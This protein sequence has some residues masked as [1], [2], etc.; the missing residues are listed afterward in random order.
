MTRQLVEA[1]EGVEASTLTRRASWRRSQTVDETGSGQSTLTRGRSLRA[2]LSADE[3]NQSTL[4]RGR[5][6]RAQMSAEEPGNDSTLT[7]R[8]NV[9]EAKD[10]ST[11]NVLSQAS[12]TLH[13]TMNT[14][15]AQTQK[16]R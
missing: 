8:R 14:L 15:L 1:K 3:S 6:L 2:Q 10:I 12:R 11:S 5:S 9:S 4:T 13:E 7:R 16:I